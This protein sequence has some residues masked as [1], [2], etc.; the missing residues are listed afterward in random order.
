MKLL[1]RRYF[2]RSSSWDVLGSST[3]T[4]PKTASEQSSDKASPGRK[5]S[6]RAICWSGRR[7]SKRRS[8]GSDSWLGLLY[9][10]QFTEKHRSCPHVSPQEPEHIA[11]QK[12]KQETKRKESECTEFEIQR[13]G[14]NPQPDLLVAVICG[15]T[16]REAKRHVLFLM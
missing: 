16:Y 7:R 9:K 2:W 4:S 13:Q 5:A 11:S 14:I 3:S 1:R 15:K 8:G 12:H 10:T 6:S